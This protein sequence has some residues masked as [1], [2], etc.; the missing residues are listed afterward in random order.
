MKKLFA[1]VLSIFLILSPYAGAEYSVEGGKIEVKN[2]NITIIEK[3]GELYVEDTTVAELERLF[4]AVKYK[5][6]Y[7]MPQMLYPAIFLRKLPK[8]FDQIED[9]SYR[10]R[11]FIQLLAP[12]AIKVANDIAKEREDMLAMKKEFE[13]G[14]SL[15]PEQSAQLEEWAERYDIFTRLKGD[16]HTSYVFDELQKKMDIIPPSMLIGVAAIESNWGTSRPAKEANSL[17]KEKVW[18]GEEKGLAPILGE[19]EE[20]DDYEFKI[21]DS[22][23]DAMRSYSIKISSGVD[24]YYIR[25]YRAEFRRREKPVSGR[26]LAHAMLHSSQLKNFA[27]LLDYTITFYEMDN[28]DIA[29]LLRMPE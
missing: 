17:Y 20:D 15:T 3:N 18:F 14:N 19:E 23:Y 26:T 25:S 2:D 8:D 22:I 24:F 7:F 4:S 10:N 21:F 27:G 28:L 1:I 5:D 16:A 13:Q 11:F 29:R 12:V 9:E 6:Y